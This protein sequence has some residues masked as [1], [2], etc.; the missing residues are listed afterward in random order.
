[1]QMQVC[2]VH[3]SVVHPICMKPNPWECIR[4]LLLLHLQHGKHTLSC[5][6]SPKFCPCLCLYWS[7][8]SVEVSQH[9]IVIL[10]LSLPSCWC[11]VAS[12]W[13]TVLVYLCICFLNFCICV[14]VYSSTFS[15][16]V[17]VCDHLVRGLLHTSYTHARLTPSCTLC[18][19]LSQIF[20]S[21]WYLRGVWG[22]MQQSCVN[23]ICDT[24][25]TFYTP[26]TVL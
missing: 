11:D 1:M 9:L 13:P 6:L 16:M 7:L 2:S 18:T 21:W 26:Y 14:F 3:C 23:N 17:L 12:L 19:S 20:S 22:G 4:I 15:P 8:I 10:Y 25:Y 24:M 5:N